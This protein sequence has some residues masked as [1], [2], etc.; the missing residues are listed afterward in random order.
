MWPALVIPLRFPPGNYTLTSGSELVIYKGLTL[1]GEGAVAT[2]IQAA[3]LPGVASFRVFNITGGNVAISGLTIRHGKPTGNGGGILNEGELT[4][5]NSTI[6]ANTASDNRG[7]IYNAGG[8]VT[9][10]NSTITDNTA[11]RGGGIR[12][13]GGGMVTLTN[14][15]ITD[16]TPTRGGG[17]V[18]LTNS[19]ISGNTAPCGGGG[20][21]NQGELTLT[22]GTVSGNSAN[23]GDGIVNNTGTL[24][25]TNS[26]VSG[27]SAS[28]S[29]SGGGVWNGDSGGVAELPNVTISGNSAS[30][31]GGISNEVGALTLT[32]STITDNTATRGGGIDISGGTVGGTNTI[33]ADNS[34]GN[35]CSGAFISLGHNLD[36]DGSCGLSLAGDIS[37]Q[38]PR[39]GPLRETTAPPSP[40][41]CRSAAPL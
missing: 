8:T 28:G 3:S 15:T 36:S 21:Y 31:G 40:M 23:F 39:L 13:A 12:N 32:N 10:T 22:N 24:T 27:N 20:I 25:I 38:A 26:T 35:D 18:T 9:L 37:E 6:G 17:T 19:T 29:G 7:G 16:N 34:S 1:F 41:P 4:L 11:T 33:I 5:A 2:R 14:S 30:F